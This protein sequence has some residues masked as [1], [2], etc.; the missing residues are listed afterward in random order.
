MKR[1]SFRDRYLAAFLLS[2]GLV[3]AQDGAALYQQTCASCHDGG[4]DRAPSREAL[5]AMTADRV[6]AAMESGP[7]ISMA[8]R[9][10]AANRRVLAEF[11]TGKSWAAS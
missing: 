10:S 11:I 7:M 8:S 6:L 2:A 9:H 5:R 3:F 1:L 4:L